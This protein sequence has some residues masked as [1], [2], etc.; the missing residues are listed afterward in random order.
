M[1]ILVNRFTKAFLVIQFNRRTPEIEFIYP[2]VDWIYRADISAVGNF[3]SHYWLIDG[4]DNITLMSEAQRD[5]VDADILQAE[6]DATEARFDKVEALERAF[7]LVVLDEINVLRAIHSL[8]DR[9]IAQ[10]KTA[11]R[12]KLGT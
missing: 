7:A 4:S 9:T 8:V 1:T 6:R 10:L 12:G 11:V 2:L 3:P 5:V